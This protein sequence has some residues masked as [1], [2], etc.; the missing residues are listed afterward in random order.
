MAEVSAIV[1]TYNAAPWIERPLESLRGTGAEVIVVDNGSTDGTLVLVREQFPEARIVEQ[2]NRGFGAGNNT[3]MRAASGRYFLLLNPDAWLTE[4]ALEDLVAFLDGHPE[5]AVVGPRLLNPDGSLQRS[6]RGYPTPWR[7]ATEYFFLRK[8]APHTEALNALFGAGFDHK[9]VREA[10]YLFGAC[11]LVRREAVDSIGGFDEDFFLMSEEVDWLYRFR[12]AGW[13]VLFYPGAEAYHVVGASLNPDAWLTEGALETLVAFADEHPEAAVVGPRLL[14]PDGSLQRSVRGYPSPWRI[15]TEY[16]FLRK[17]APHSHALNAF[18]GEQFDHESVREAEYLFGACLL[19]RREAVDAVG[20]FDEDFFLMSEEVD[21]CYRFRQA[22][23]KILFFPGAE[24]THVVGA[25]L[26]P[27][28]F[29]AIVR[30][31]LQF[32]RKHRGLR[33]A[34][35]ARRVMLWGLR[36]RGVFFRGDR[37]RAYREAAQ[38]LGS[39]NTAA[40]LESAR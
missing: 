39:G 11:L 15:A 18:F 20:G 34:E 22:G 29:K 30:G 16:F 5:A 37:G 8:L 1:V 31:H 38:W 17:L 6:V 28:Q 36:L 12:Q 27:R 4:G 33:V 32:L 40:L 3:G 13:K 25:S 23:W 2:E 7:L 14:N 24:V 26:N 10:D 19:V 9:S 35:R 21:W